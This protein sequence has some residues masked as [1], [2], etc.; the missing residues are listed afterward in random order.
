MAKVFI[1]EDDDSLRDLYE[2]GLLLKGHEVIG[3]ASDGN[4]AID[5]F[6][7][8]SRKPDIIVMDHR[9]PGKNG[10]EVTKEIMETD[11]KSLIIFASADKSVKDKAIS[12]GAR[13]FKV[14][15]FTLEKLCYNIKKALDSRYITNAII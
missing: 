7:N 10:L 9:M 3:C 8:F 15:P 4:E 13:S 2:L 12:L 11:S 6:K 5:M 14:K 1:V